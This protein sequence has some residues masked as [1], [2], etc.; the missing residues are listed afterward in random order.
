[1][2]AAIPEPRPVTE[3]VSLA[4]FSLAFQRVMTNM[5]TSAIVAT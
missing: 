3:E 5:V 4:S 1:M 2:N